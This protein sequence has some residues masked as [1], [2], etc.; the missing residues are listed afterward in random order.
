MHRTNFG[1]LKDTAFFTGALF[2]VP[3]TAALGLKK[4][5]DRFNEH[6]QQR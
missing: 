1:W 3:A 6:K 5:L 4:L 2:V